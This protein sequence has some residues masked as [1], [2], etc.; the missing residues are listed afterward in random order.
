MSPT[1]GVMSI[2]GAAYESEIPLTHHLLFM[3]EKQPR[4]FFKAISKKKTLTLIIQEPLER[5][6]SVG[7]LQPIIVRRQ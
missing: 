4:V 2:L 6:R 3:L 1:I 7:K 5:A